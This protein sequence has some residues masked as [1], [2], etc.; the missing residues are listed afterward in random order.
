MERP[1]FL[2]ERINKTYSVNS[3]FWA[4]S[5]AEFPFQLIYP[6]LVVIIAYY[7]IGLNDTD[8]K[9]FFTLSTYCFY[10]F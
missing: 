9:L 7:V 10:L 1:L 2:R 5:L 6:A 8:V 3:F 4:R